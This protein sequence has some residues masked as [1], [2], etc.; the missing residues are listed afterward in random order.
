M[1]KPV[2]VL[3]PGHGGY[4]PGATYNGL[5]E[6]DL[7]LALAIKVASRLDGVKT[8]LT[9]ERDIYVSLADRVALS[10]RA[11]ANLFIS[12]HANAGG[13]KG[14][15]SFIYRGLGAKD[16]AVLMQQLLHRAVM[17]AIDR[18]E[19]TDRG[20]KRASFYVLRSNPRPAILIESLFLDNLREAQI[21]REPLFAETLAGGL[22]DGIKNALALSDAEPPR[23]ANPKAAG[24]KR[25]RT[26]GLYTVQVGAFSHL[27]NARQRLAEA[28]VA[29]FRD[30]FIYQKQ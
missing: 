8:L 22:V 10:R 21:W 28:Q 20:L 4:D 1:Q 18:W 19:I 3:D 14:F 29:G 6:K 25:S 26:S 11:E 27:E 13:G 24:F 30:A 23:P 16:P 17:K 2:V 12:L 15:E 9:R 5:K 7:N